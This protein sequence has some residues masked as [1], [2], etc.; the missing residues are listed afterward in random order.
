MHGVAEGGVLFDGG[1]RLRLR[2]ELD[3]VAGLITSY[4]YEAERG[5]ERLVW[6]D[7]F[8][9]PEDPLSAPTFP[10]HKHIPPDIRH[11]RIPAPG[12]SF[13][14]PNLPVVLREIEAIPD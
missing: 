10:H 2:V 3:F 6:Y 11:H 4:G 1:V 5:A 7:D 8:P 9:P 13:S 12:M 14:T